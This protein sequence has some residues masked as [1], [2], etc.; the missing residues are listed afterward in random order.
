MAH[1]IGIGVT[2]TPNREKHLLL[3]LE[4]YGNYLPKGS[5][6]L[7][8]ERDVTGAGIAA[9]K[10]ECLKALQGNDYIFLFDDDCFPIAYD[11]AEFFIAAYKNTGENHFLY[12][13]R[14]HQLISAQD[15]IGKYKD[16]GGCMMF[17]TRAVIEQVGGYYKGY[18]VY[19]FEHAGYSNR[20]Y[21]A[22]L[23]TAPYL[24]PI[25]SGKYIYSLDLDLPRFDIKHFRSIPTNRAINLITANLEHY[26][27]DIKIIL[28]PL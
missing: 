1:K 25:D 14:S 16:S 4:Q 10:N 26:K 24:S 11:W 23:N 17:L 20:I 3:W 12:L 8:I 2:T 9:S 7:H 6:Q 15:N 19:G 22:G 27:E 18:G 28:R 5:V 21:Q 13:N